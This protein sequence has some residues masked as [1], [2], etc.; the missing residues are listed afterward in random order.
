MRSMRRGRLG[1][2]PNPPPSSAPAAAA[3][4]PAARLCRRTAFEPDALRAAHPRAQGAGAGEEGRGLGARCTLA[5][6]ELRG[7]RRCQLP[8]DRLRHAGAARRR[9]GGAGLGLPAAAAAVRHLP[10]PA[11]GGDRAQPLRPLRIAGAVR[12]PSPRSRTKRNRSAP[13]SR[14]RWRWRLATPCTA[15]FMAPCARGDAGAER[16]PRTAHLRR[17]GARHGKPVPAHQPLDASTRRCCRSP[18]YGW[19]ISA[20]SSPSRCWRPPRGCCW[21]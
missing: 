7:G 15:P 12:H 5:G 10:L 8:A 17:A 6:R 21:C 1:T 11:D 20:S 4:A 3:A 2:S 9:R 14:A 13:S 18:A 16:P 19:C